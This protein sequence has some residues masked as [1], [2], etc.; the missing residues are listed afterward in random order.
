M[1]NA[2]RDEPWSKP[3]SKLPHA[4]RVLVP[5]AKEDEERGGAHDGADHQH[6][7]EGGQAPPVPKIVEDP[8]RDSWARRGR[9]QHAGVLDAEDANPI[10]GGHRVGE[11]G[12]HVG[13]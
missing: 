13:V 4:E 2:K 11:D 10:A 8:D 12:L 6:D 5:E 7:P 9:G 1:R 3:M